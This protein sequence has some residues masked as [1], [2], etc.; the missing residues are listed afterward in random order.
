M[1]NLQDEG[2]DVTFLNVDSEGLV[3]LDELKAAIRQAIKN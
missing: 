1:R 2:F 3:N